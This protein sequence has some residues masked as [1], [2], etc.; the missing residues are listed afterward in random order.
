M[1]VRFGRLGYLRPLLS[2]AILRD[3]GNIQEMEMQPL[4]FR[5]TWGRAN[6]CRQEDLRRWQRWVRSSLPTQRFVAAAAAVPATREMRLR[7]WWS[8]LRRRILFIC[9][10]WDD[11]RDVPKSARWLRKWLRATALTSESARR[12]GEKRAVFRPSAPRIASSF[13]RWKLLFFRQVPWM[14]VLFKFD[15]VKVMGVTRI[16]LSVSLFLYQ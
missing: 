12:P 4:K 8:K 16:S 13:A 3:F 1:T 14:F 9:G 11:S 6:T 7:L 10:G 5:I 15:R 2:T